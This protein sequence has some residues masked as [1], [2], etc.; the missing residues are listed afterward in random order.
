MLNIYAVHPSSV[1]YLLFFKFSFIFH[2]FPLSYLNIQPMISG[3]CL[4]Y[5]CSF[6]TIGDI[7][8]D[9]YFLYSFFCPPNIYEAIIFNNMQQKYIKSKVYLFI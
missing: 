3:A 1:N 6:L 2:P 7:T 9:A 8:L 4:N 5:Y